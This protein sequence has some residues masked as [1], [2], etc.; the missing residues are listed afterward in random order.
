MHVAL[1]CNVTNAS[2]SCTLNTIKEGTAIA[3][4]SCKPTCTHGA[5]TLT[6]RTLDTRKS[7][8]AATAIKVI[9][10][11]NVTIGVAELSLAMG[12]RPGVAGASTDMVAMTDPVAGGEP[13]NL[14]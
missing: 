5:P 8:V 3:I 1:L 11:A 9:A 13:L 10:I 2:T 4:W 7:S 12:A 6:G 14:R